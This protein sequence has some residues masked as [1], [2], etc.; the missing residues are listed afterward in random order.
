MV[1]NDS[2]STSFQY[3]NFLALLGHSRHPTETITNNPKINMNYPHFYEKITVPYGVDIIGWPCQFINPS[4]LSEADLT[5]L[6][7]AWLDKTCHFK[8]LTREEKKVRATKFEADVAAGTVKRATRK[9]RK[10]KGGTHVKSC[11]VIEDDLVDNEDSMGAD[12]DHRDNDGGPE[13]ENNGDEEE[14]PDSSENSNAE[15]ENRE[16]GADHENNATAPVQ[17]STPPPTSEDRV[18]LSSITNAPAGNRPKRTRNAPARLPQLAAPK[19]KRAADGDIPPK[20]R[21]K[22]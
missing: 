19:L 7:D 21:R 3:S 9:S 16:L 13:T 17:H 10:D 2:L 5:R 14:D 12:D 1:I 15:N 18:P 6:R 4:L 20:K 8:K 22:A 11:K